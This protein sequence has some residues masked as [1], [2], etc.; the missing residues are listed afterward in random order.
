MKNFG[1]F[2]VM[3]ALSLTLV[4]C[5]GGAASSAAT[6]AETSAAT[7]V[8]TSAATSDATATSV[9]ST[10]ATTPAAT[11]VIGT[12]KLAAMEQ[13]GIL[14]GGDMT[15][16]L[17]M[18]GELEGKDVGGDLM[19]ITIAEGGK[20]SMSM[21]GESYDITWTETATGATLTPVATEQNPE[22]TSID[23]TLEGNALSL[24]MDENKVYFTP[25][26]KYDALKVY[27]LTAAKDVSSESELVGDWNLASMSMMGITMQGDA[28]TMAN[29]MG[30][31]GTA[32]SFATG[33]KCT[34]F[35]SETTYVVGTDGASI[36][37][38]GL[39][40][41]L[42]ML[43]GQLV[44]DMGSAYGMDFSLIFTKA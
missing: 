9:A 17:Q 4:A 35:G 23:A 32:L 33:G 22:P 27:D 21:M 11:S 41:P 15:A 5:G 3:G 19:V 24:M 42:K 44:I 25:D 18:T 8:A 20:G 39:K 29:Q 28:A 40:M 1:R 13:N 6:S 7:S 36:T 10:I 30:L 31:E 34:A 38:E 43:D 26:G 12:W 16:A 37:D 14:M 2:A